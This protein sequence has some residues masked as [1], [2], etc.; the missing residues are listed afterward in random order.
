MRTHEIQPGPYADDVR[1]SITI[2]NPNRSR[3]AYDDWH[4]TL[5]TMEGSPTD[6][7]VSGDDIALYRAGVT[8][9]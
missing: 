5:R 3:S 2:P 9:G 1:L 7:P 4:W 8:R 6:W